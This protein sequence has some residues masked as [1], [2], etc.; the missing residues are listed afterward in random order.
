[1]RSVFITHKK[2]LGFDLNITG[3][4]QLCSQEFYRFL[5]YCGFEIEPYYVE[6]NRNIFS[7]IRIKLQLDCYD[8]YN[9]KKDKI[10][11]LRHIKDNDI[12]YVF[13]NHASAVR[14]SEVLKQYFGESI[15]ICLLSHGND[16]GDFLHTLTKPLNKPHGIKLY[17][18]VFKLGR[19]LYYETLSRNRYLNMILTVSEVEKEI[20]NWIGAKKVF[21]IPR[22][23]H[24][25]FKS[26]LKTNYKKGG[27]MGRLDHQ[28]NFIGFKKLCESLK[29]Y[30]AKNDFEI[31]LVGAP[32]SL[33]KK[34]QKEYSFVNYKGELSD[35]ELVKEVSTWSF[36]FNPVFWYS[37]GVSTKL[38]KAIE[39]EV[40]VISTTYG[41]RGYFWNEG[42]IIEK[43]TPEEMAEFFID[44]I[45]NKEI[46][47]YHKKEIIKIKQSSFSLKELAEN[48]KTQIF[49]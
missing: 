36:I 30:S 16:S 22:A 9:I 28:P 31:S 42:E 19:L 24:K 4:V 5:E 8:A 29:Q 6:Y 26:E 18:Q 38:A 13:I 33:G 43:N 3:G 40:P 21:Y 14:Y 44:N 46:I 35:I 1:M 48:Y 27:F 41:N 39:W 47:N 37:M 7:R 15:K 2:L 10:S 49:D 34:F 45:N 17:K 20:E 11:L 32:E 12:K 23:I 25:E